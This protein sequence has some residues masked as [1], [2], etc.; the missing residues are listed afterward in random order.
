[1]LL[2]FTLAG[3]TSTRLHRIDQYE[4]D[5]QAFPESIRKAIHD[6]EVLTGFTPLQVYLALGPPDRNGRFEPLPVEEGTVW[7]YIGFEKDGRF[8][9]TSDLVF[10]A[11]GPLEILRIRFG[12]RKTVISIHR[13]PA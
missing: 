12:A 10:R 6:G 7:T 4:R 8:F 2:C 5:F 3:C 11:G 9:T 1:M 13:E